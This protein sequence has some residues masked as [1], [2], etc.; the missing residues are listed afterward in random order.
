MLTEEEIKQVL[1]K[2][3]TNVQDITQ[4]LVCY[5]HERKGIE[6]NLDPFF[7]EMRDIHFMF[8]LQKY[9]LLLANH[10]LDF[11]TIKYNLEEYLLFHPKN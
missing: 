10:V 7:E 11:Y 5:I 9:Y 4:L 2:K 3:V 8:S 1:K 6:V